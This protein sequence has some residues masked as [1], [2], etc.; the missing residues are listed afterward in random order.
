MKK[1]AEMTFP[2]SR[3]SIAK[4]RLVLG[5]AI[6]S[7]LVFASVS[8]LRGVPADPRPGVDDI[9]RILVTHGDGAQTTFAASLKERTGVYGLFSLEYASGTPRL[10]AVR[11]VGPSIDYLIEKVVSTTAA[12][13]RLEPRSEPE[14]NWFSTA[15]AP[16]PRVFREVWLRRNA[17]PRTDSSNRA[18]PPGAD[19][20]L[21]SFPKRT[22]RPG[23]SL[24]ALVG[25]S[26]RSD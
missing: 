11:P 7:G 2:L 5:G 13:A 19:S 15:A 6:A 9:E 12:S 26:S 21:G 18:A 20:R 24:R 8:V 1:G 25:R 17:W 3:S 16:M 14:R 10:E 23:F 4:L 22:L